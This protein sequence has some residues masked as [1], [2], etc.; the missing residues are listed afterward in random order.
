MVIHAWQLHGIFPTSTEVAGCLA[1]SDDEMEGCCPADCAK[2]ICSLDAPAIMEDN[3]SPTVKSDSSSGAED[4][5]SAAMEEDC[6]SP[7]AS[8]T[9]IEDGLS[10]AVTEDLSHLIIGIANKET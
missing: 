1:V 9:A 5:S 4:G 7:A 2:K 10:V 3:F 6:S 8:S